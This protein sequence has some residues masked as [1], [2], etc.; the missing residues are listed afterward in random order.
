[1]AD[2][3]AQ[4]KQAHQLDIKSVG[5]KA[6]PLG[7]LTEN[8]INIPNGFVV[9][10]SVF[11]TLRKNAALD[12]QIESL[13]HKLQKERMNNVD[14]VSKDI[15]K[16]LESVTIPDNVES[17]ILD[18]FTTLNTKYVAVRSSSAS[19]DQEKYSWA[20]EFETY[21]FITKNNLVQN[22]IRCW[23]SLYTP[24]AL[25]YA[26]K[27]NLP[28]ASDMA[29][30]VQQMIE[31]EIAGV[32]FTREPNGAD[33]NVLLIEAIHGMGE[34]LVHGDVTPDRYWVNKKE[35][36]ILDIEISSQKKMIN[37][38]LNNIKI[39]ENSKSDE[40]KL[41]GENIIELA[42]TAIEIEKLMGKPQDI[43][44]AFFNNQLFIIQARPITG[45]NND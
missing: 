13:L 19:E 17:T 12:I 26:Y 2:I 7:F 23:A 43:E 22:I 31:S 45:S 25:M 37:S 5:G 32:C 21:T 44:W 1:M 36:I 10:S 24:R 3:I 28:F 9:L 29:V 18:A 39:V 33:D 27:H 11:N 40:Q 6:Y 42:R 8:N 4:L 41:N 34:L 15:R 16:L 30:L 38:V 14:E 35:D 20:G